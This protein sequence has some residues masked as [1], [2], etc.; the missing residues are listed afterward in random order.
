M[1]GGQRI[2]DRF[3][4]FR[5]RNRRNQGRDKTAPAIGQP[6]CRQLGAHMVAMAPLGRGQS[7]VGTAAEQQ[8]TDVAVAGFGK[9]RETENL[10]WQRLV[11][12]GPVT[13]LSRLV[14]TP[15][16]K[17][18][19]VSNAT[20]DSIASGKSPRAACLRRTRAQPNCG[21]KHERRE[22]PGMTR[23][24][25]LFCH[26]RRVPPPLP[27]RGDNKVTVHQQSGSQA[28]PFKRAARGEGA[29]RLRGRSRGPLRRLQGRTFWKAEGARD[30]C[31]S[32]FSFSTDAR[33]QRELATRF[34][35][36][37][38]REVASAST[39][40]GVVGSTRRE[41]ASASTSVGVVGER[42]SGLFVCLVCLFVVVV[43][44]LE[45]VQINLGAGCG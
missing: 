8:C 28:I 17:R 39:S 19:P 40:V 13:Q 14:A 10:F 26:D 32:P 45:V 44:V 33:D 24:N 11:D 6:S 4:R 34:A 21:C 35:Q 12:S 23:A 7:P 41:V 29:P 42:R 43:V 37:T 5:R 25:R 15:A 1:D 20:R 31:D 22:E 27:P 38:R 9:M 3:C 36:S 30:G 16:P 2:A 18:A